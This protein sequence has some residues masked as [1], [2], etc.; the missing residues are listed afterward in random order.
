MIYYNLHRS[1]GRFR[2]ILAISILY[3]LLFGIFGCEAVAR[4]F[5]RKPKREPP[6]E[7]LVLVPEEYSGPQM[8]KEELY[9]QYFIFWKSW[10]GELVESLAYGTNQKKRIDTVTEAIKNLESMG[11]L[12]KEGSK[13]EL[14]L[15]I[16][17]M[18]QLKD[19][20]KK[21]I[22][23]A[24][25]HRYRLDAERIKANILR[26]FSYSKIKDSLN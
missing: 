3:V 13:T 26:D 5:T 15:Y 1:N 8:T 22:Y 18:K 9:R 10:Q 6:K 12:L 4:K 16:N 11:T 17:Q 20:I 24:H 19:A 14:D 7:E 2:C 25:S 23:G 21:D